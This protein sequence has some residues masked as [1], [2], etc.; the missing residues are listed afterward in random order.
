MD[1]GKIAASTLPQATPPAAGVTPGLRMEAGFL[2]S[3]SPKPTEQ[4]GERQKKYVGDAIEQIRTQMQGLQ[5]N[6][7]FNI[8]DSTGDVV[9]QVIDGDSGK[10]V[11]QIPSEEILR[12]A[13]RLDEMRSLLF[14]TKA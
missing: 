14:E 5:R 3:G 10:V 1:V 7:N 11:R 13:E 2:S 9:V 4:G 8:D 6:L 12:L